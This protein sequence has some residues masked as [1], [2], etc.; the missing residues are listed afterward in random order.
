MKE[1]DFDT[2]NPFFSVDL[3]TG[4]S[5]L[6]SFSKALDDNFDNKILEPVSLITVDL[7]QL[8]D[9]NKRKGFEYG[10]GVW[11]VPARTQVLCSSKRQNY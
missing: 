5:N 4:C 10:P 3:L 7:Y 6:V 8:R 2:P 11:D 1:K 9:I